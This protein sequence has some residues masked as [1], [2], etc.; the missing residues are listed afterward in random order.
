MTRLWW[1]LAILFWLFVVALVLLL[2]GTA[3][4]GHDLLAA[5]DTSGCAA[6][7]FM[8]IQPGIT[9]SSMAYQRLQTHPWTMEVNAVL[10]TA[11]TLN[12]TREALLIWRWN[13][14]EPLVLH[15]PFLDAGEVDVQTGV[16]RSI[17]LRTGIS[18][19]MVWLTLGRPGYGYTQLSKN[20]L[21]R[22]ANQ[23]AYYPRWGLVVQTL[24]EYPP[25]PDGFWN[26]PVDLFWTNGTPQNNNYQAP[27]WM[28]CDD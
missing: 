27:C 5:L 17:R 11:D 6:P 1:R 21:G 15:T 24:I 19:G 22:L 14:R 9:S 8:N 13:G 25:T 23:F 16:V 20:Y 3:W 12:Q 7:C 4:D 26:A 18:F 10:S 2:Q 28:H